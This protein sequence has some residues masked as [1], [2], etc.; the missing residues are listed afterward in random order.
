[1][2][3]VGHARNA[4]RR[5]RNDT[6]SRAAEDHVAVLKGKLE[7]YEQGKYVGGKCPNQKQKNETSL[8]K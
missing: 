2:A 6:L 7:Q 3:E 1:M 8:Q 5:A 4:A